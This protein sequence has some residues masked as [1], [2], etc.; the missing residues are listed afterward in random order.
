MIIN[1]H[2]IGIDLG[3]TNSVV[4]ILE[5]EQPRVIHNSE[6][7]T[8]TPSV[9]S[10]LENG[11]V[12]VGEIARR[13]TAVHPERS[14][15]SIKR[16][17]GRTLDDV[18]ALEITVP[19]ELVE[20][21]GQ[22]MVKIDDQGFTPSQISAHVLKKLKQSAEDY[23]GTEVTKAIVT[24]PAYFDDLQRQA[25]MEAGKLAG[26][27]V[28]RLVNEP[29]AAAMA[30]GLGREGT[31]RVVV[32]DFGGGTFDVTVLEITDNTF[33]V[34]TST[35]DTHLGG[36][37]LDDILAR[38]ML[39]Y[40]SSSQRIEVVPDAM[41]LRRL[42]DAAEKAKCELSGAR[43]T[44]VHL[45]FLTYNAGQPVHL[46]MKITREELEDLAIP[47]VERTIERCRMALED[48][49]LEPGQVDK[50][51]LVGGST[52]MP[53]V[54]EL[55]EEFFGVPPFKGINP[56]E[57]V[58]MGAATQAG[59]LGG[60]LKEVILLDVTP[61]SLG[62]EVA[63]NKV[64]RIVEKNSTI[65]IKTAKHFTT[66]EDNQETVVVHVC[67]GES[68]KASE[69]RSL[70]KFMLTGV[71]QAAAGVPRI[72]VTFHINAN[73]MVEVSAEDL[74]TKE[75][76]SVALTLG[77]EGGGNAARERVRGADKAKTQSRRRRS[78]RSA[79]ASSSDVI[80]AKAQQSSRPD[81]A[82]SLRQ[83]SE[84]PN[85]LPLHGDADTALKPRRLESDDQ[86]K[87]EPS[88][89]VSYRSLKQRPGEPISGLRSTEAPTD[90][91]AGPEE[92]ATKPPAENELAV[93]MELSE[94]ARQ[95]LRHAANSETGSQAMIAYQDSFEELRRAANKAPG[96]LELVLPTARILAILGERNPARELLLAAQALPTVPPSNIAAAFDFFLE[97]FPGDEGA[98]AG[99][100]T[101]LSRMGQ[102]DSAISDYERIWSDDAG[103]EAHAEKLIELYQAKLAMGGGDSAETQFKLV[104]LFVRK[105][106][107]DDAVNILQQ[108]TLNE[109][110]KE[111]SLKIL[112]LCY[113]QKGMHYL[114]WQKFQQLPP[115]EE[116]KDI[117]YR[118]A[119]DMENTDQL[120]NAKAVLQFLL[121]TDPTYRDVDARLTK[122][123]QLLASGTSGN[124]G[125]SPGSLFMA[126]K[127]SRFVIIEEINRG[128]MGIV[129]RAKDKILDEVVALKILTDYLTTDPTAVE[130]FKREARAAKR[131]SHPNIVRIHD[132]FEI[133]GKKLLSME[134]IEGRDLKKILS[135]Q[136]M[137]PVEDIVEISQ[138]VCDA[139]AY[140]HQLGIVHRDIKPANIMITNDGKVKVTDFGI[141]KFLL[142]GP[143]VT[144]SGS[145][146]LGTPLYMSPEQIRGD[147]IDI[148]SDIYSFG[149]MLYE[150]AC[151]KPPFWEGNIEYHH[152]HTA[153][154]ELT[155][156]LPDPVRATIMKCL[157]KE[158]ADRI[159]T[160]DE[161]MRM[162]QVAS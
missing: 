50:V 129:Y 19:Y 28:L 88:S 22:L 116:I 85:F 71:Q 31:E 132:M 145:Q 115:T 86:A 97:K 131:L 83:P 70:G 150:M 6:G 157:A 40:L 54:Q 162:L 39:E 153:P 141:A 59:V 7:S 154:P 160:V 82:I 47:L 33:E 118:L 10:F 152:L 91:L 41:A 3:T 149:A 123:E 13:Q 109:N 113:W 34:L 9:V 138:G 159:Q 126:F 53:L 156:D 56:D 89:K 73:G 75:Q 69:N 64:S 81:F 124:Q 84:S 93:T 144:R 121:D 36:D 80:P 92:P 119:T 98:L 135:E 139:L 14:V 140:A 11:D 151:G 4:A 63:E 95:A 117:V 106:R 23:L 49:N 120:L 148:R 103:N 12:V 105:S 2:I 142:A 16:I 52:R 143:E 134:Y 99:R 37:D 20:Q 61:H 101:A 74:V 114:A 128:S 8:K 147:Q 76:R 51:I 38:Q 108:L 79:S 35:G 110:F 43:Q 45:P 42:K 90:A 24:V 44:S 66:T 133:G 155:V 30:Y 67:Q 122:L 65:P 46:E 107:V 161:V 48:C 25:T 127:D 68:E 5:N 62:V 1:D 32:Y 130:R 125:G 27:E 17:M 21:D 77:G 104:K 137:L 102:I 112:G 146:I 158:V 29:T 58:G 55:V 78:G 87:D 100:A 94:K 57:I 26:L 96:N 18:E 15:T 111:R 60:K 72:Q 136:S